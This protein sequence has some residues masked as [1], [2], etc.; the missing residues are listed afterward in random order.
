MV[1]APVLGT[2][3]VPLVK[4]YTPCGFDP[5]LPHQ[6]TATVYVNLSTLAR[7]FRLRLFFT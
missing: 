3:G 5:R 7:Y 4:D 1:A 2:G 6:T